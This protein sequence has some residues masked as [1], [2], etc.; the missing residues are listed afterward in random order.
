[1]RRL[2]IKGISEDCVISYFSKMNQG[3]KIEL[4]DS[5]FKGSSYGFIADLFFVE[6]TKTDGSVIV[7]TD[8][9]FDPTKSP[10][11]L[12]FKLDGHEFNTSS[13][14]GPFEFETLFENDTKI[15]SQMTPSNIG[16]T[17]LYDRVLVKPDEQ[18]EQ[19]QSGI[20]IPV[21][22]RKKSNIGTV[23]AV[24]EGTP[25]QPMFLKPGDRI[26]YQRYAGLD[27][28]WDN[29]SYAI[30]LTHE[31]I[32]KIDPNFKSDLVYKDQNDSN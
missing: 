25:A 8:S 9:F 30:I 20:I 10:D 4:R 11:Q 23:V 7:N 12:Y 29:Q 6:I 5:Y 26:L 27:V 31:V 17:P 28:E 18:Q 32:A 15:E 3:Q 1:M 16:I 19:T 24:G 13:T 22:S 2:K 14:A 21:D